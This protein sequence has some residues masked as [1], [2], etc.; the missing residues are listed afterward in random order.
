MDLGVDAKAVYDSITTRHLKT[1]DDK[2]LILHA[3]AM[4]E[5]LDNGHVDRLYW[6]GTDDM[7]PDGLTK[8]SIERESLIKCCL[9]GI[10]SITHEVPV[11][12]SFN[13]HREEIAAAW[14]ANLLAISAGR[15]D[16]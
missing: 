12:W 11:Q 3:R 6:F 16:A 4:R 13:E 9:K 14:H 2:H 8:G 15:P 1:P 5:F 10:W 7:L